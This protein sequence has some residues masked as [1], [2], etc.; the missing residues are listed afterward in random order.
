METAVKEASFDGVTFSYMESRQQNRQDMLAMNG[1][2]F[3]LGIV[4]GAVFLMAT[5]LIIYYKQI[6]EGFEDKKRYEIM[7]K[8]GMSQK[9]VRQSIRSQTV[10]V[11]FL[12]LGM[13]VIHIAGSL[14]AD[15]P[16]A[17]GDESGQLAAV[18]G[19]HG[20]N[21]AGIRGNLFPGIQSD[22]Q[23]LLPYCKMRT[24]AAAGPEGK[25]VISTGE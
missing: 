11:F 9:E 12:P 16:G 7:E 25:T 4:L 13:A 18:S 23:N 5:V 19:L 22:G 6:S 8:V 3:F 24:Q 21:G 14:S 10:K 1:S 20:G 2:F 17:A 15:A